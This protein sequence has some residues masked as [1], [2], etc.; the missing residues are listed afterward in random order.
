MDLMDRPLYKMSGPDL[1][2]LLQLIEVLVAP[3]ENLKEEAKVSS[4]ILEE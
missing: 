1:E 3:L 2:E 4:Y